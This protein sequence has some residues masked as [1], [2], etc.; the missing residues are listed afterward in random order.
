MLLWP[1]ASVF[2]SDANAPPP[3]T[4]AAADDAARAPAGASPRVDPIDPRTF[5]ASGDR[6]TDD[7]KA[8]QASLDAVP[9]G[10]TWHLRATQRGGYRISATLLVTNAI[11]I[12][13]DGYGA[14]LWVDPS[15]PRDAD[16]L[17]FRPRSA[18]TY[19][20]LAI[21]GLYVLPLNGAPGRDGIRVDVSAPGVALH[22]FEITH[23]HVR[24]LAGYAL[25]VVNARR[26]HDAFFSS[27]IAENIFTGGI[28]LNGA[29]DSISIHRNTLSWHRS[30]LPAG[31]NAGVTVELISSDDPQPNGDASMLS[32]AYNNITATGGAVW[33]KRGTRT[34]IDH[35]NIELPQG[36]TTQPHRA[37]IDLDGGP[38]L[39]GEPARSGRLWQAEVTQNYLGATTHHVAY[40]VR[41]HHCDDCVIADN[42][43]GLSNGYGPPGGPYD[44]QWAG[45]LVTEAARNTRLRNNSTGYAW[46]AFPKTIVDA[47][48]GTM[49]VWKTA[50]LLGSWMASGSA[51]QEVAYFKD[52]DG[53]VTFRGSVKGG[54]YTRGTSAVLQLPIGFRP[55]AQTVLP[56]QA[57]AGAT[58]GLAQVRV[59]PNGTVSAAGQQAVDGL[60]LD[61]LQ[62]WSS[63]IPTLTAR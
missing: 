24:A 36:P 23:C 13:A 53:F 15:V 55:V 32:I 42:V 2:S 39:E 17:V 57:V 43:L 37:L 28:N 48:Q 45:I 14:T 38:S 35:N 33:I 52:W 54:V 9:P 44:P 56:T 8:L 12:V 40:T 29:G 31:Q 47:G 27:T 63:P 10:G 6:S 30:S 25:N 5:G 59:Q 7:T 26:D 21:T 61:G 49:G 20:H 16:V 58:S 34:R 60:F 22:R 41:A 11:A 4:P 1:S 18:G 19:E 51:A 62:L 3:V 50:H 46:N